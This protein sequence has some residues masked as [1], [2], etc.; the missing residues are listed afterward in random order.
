MV[1]MQDRENG[2]KD[3]GKPGNRDE[4]SVQPYYAAFVFDPQGNN[5]EAVR[6]IK[7]GQP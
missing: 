7:K 3:N 6:L 2:G 4:M 1:L 5:I